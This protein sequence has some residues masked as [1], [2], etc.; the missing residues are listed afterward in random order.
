MYF[1]PFLT[2]TICH[3]ITI[4]SR[5]EVTLYIEL[6]GANCF[7]VKILEHLFFDRAFYGI[8]IE[9]GVTL[10]FNDCLIK[11]QNLTE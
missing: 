9:K 7:I 8:C 10:C 4:N 6:S 11:L 3:R 5:V 1:C 2:F